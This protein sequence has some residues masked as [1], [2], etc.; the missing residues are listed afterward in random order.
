GVSCFG[1]GNVDFHRHGAVPGVLQ[2][3]DHFQAA[4]V[5][6]G[7]DGDLGPGLVADDDLVPRADSCKILSEI[8]GNMHRRAAIY[9]S[10]RTLA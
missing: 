1:L 4:R 7:G 9:R 10:P 8:Y 2:G 5:P 6:T 3:L